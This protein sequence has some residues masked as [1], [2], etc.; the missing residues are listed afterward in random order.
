MPE[1]ALHSPLVS[2]TWPP[3]VTQQ[4]QQGHNSSPGL[5]AELKHGS[6]SPEL[7]SSL[8]L[9]QAEAGQ[10]PGDGGDGA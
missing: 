8:E 3:E 5:D 4:G 7:T 9:G 6:Q 10:S 1:G 2:L